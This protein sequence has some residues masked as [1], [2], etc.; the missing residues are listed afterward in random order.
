MSDRPSEFEPIFE[1]TN[2]D[3]I[4][5]IFKSVSHIPLFFEYFNFRHRNIEFTRNNEIDYKLPFLTRMLNVVVRNFPIPFIVNLHLPDFF[6]NINRFPHP[7][8]E[9]FHF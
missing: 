9:I 4:F 6:L 8:K 2:L 3:D 7:L 1:P 5:S